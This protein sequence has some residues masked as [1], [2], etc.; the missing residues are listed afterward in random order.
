M[1]LN[2]QTHPL[3]VDPRAVTP[4]RRVLVRSTLAGAIALALVGAYAV[5]ADTGST[6]LTPAAALKGGTAAGPASFADVVERVTPAVVNVAVSGTLGDQGQGHQFQMPD[7]PQGMPFPELFKRFFEERGLQGHGQG[8][9]KAVQGVGSGFIISPDGY[10][11]TNNHVVD[12]AD[13]VQVM[14][15]DGSRYRASVKGRDA[16]TDLALLK[17]EANKALP[18]VEFGDAT[19]TRVGDWV[20]AVGN[21]FGLGGTVTAGIVSARGRDIHD[22]GVDDYLQVDAPI[23][24]GNSGGPLFDGSGRVIGVNTAIFSPSGGSVGIG[25]AIPAETAK[26]VVAQL[27]DQG[28]IDRGWLGVQIQPVTEEIAEGL[29]LKGTQGALVASVVPGSPAAKAGVQPGD[30]ILSASG[31][32]LDEFKQLSRT[33]AATR[34]GTEVRLGVQRQG[35][36]QEIP[37]VIGAMP[38]DDKVADASEAPGSGVE[39]KARLGLHLAPLTKEARQAL[40]LDAQAQGVLVAKVAEGSPAERAGIRPGS[41]ISMIGQQPVSTPEELAGKVREAAKADR[42]SV[43]LLVEKEGEKRFVTVRFAA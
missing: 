31:K 7:L 13:E 43:L 32:T 39:S 14:L 18:Y 36:T 28:R 38:S 26:T 8:G 42:P 6:S 15:N 11:V 33:I 10:V 4:R 41:L 21:P 16:K 40:K 9:P 35:T 12:G 27:R 20:L 24:R 23:N 2:S 34:A 29:G 30:V 37:V 3:N 5:S 25:F 19:S 1:N 17:I 22:G